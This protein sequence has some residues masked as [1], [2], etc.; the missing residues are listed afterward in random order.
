MK[1]LTNSDI[2]YF[3]DKELSIGRMKG[4]EV[5][6]QQCEKCKGKLD[7]AQKDKNQVFT[8]LDTL[9]LSEKKIDIPPFIPA[10]TRAGNKRL[11]ALI[12]VAA[13]ALILFGV[14]SFYTHQKR[15]T[16]RQNNIK[17]ASIEVTRN[18][19]PNKMV[20]QKQIIMIIT[21]NSGDV[22][23]TSVTE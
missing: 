21:N 19:E 23:E 3:I 16:E 18:M 5:H 2:Q 11:Y 12:S 7:I 1:C 14:G 22:I 4:I 8:L 13:T 6:L 17:K 10:I 9:L 20:Q 15:I